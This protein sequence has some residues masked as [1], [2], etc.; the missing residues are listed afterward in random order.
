MSV[1]CGAVAEAEKN[2]YSDDEEDENE[3]QETADD[4]DDVN[5]DAQN[6]PTTTVSD[7]ILQPACPRKQ[8]H[9]CLKLTPFI[10]FVTY[11][12]SLNR[13]SRPLLVQLR[14]TPACI[15]GPGCRPI[16]GPASISTFTLRRTDGNIMCI[17]QKQ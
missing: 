8:C 5:N 3:E 15:R 11:R 4:D 17:S 14:Q 1:C 10:D 13:S 2:W 9:S 7:S 12:I 16:Q 6:P